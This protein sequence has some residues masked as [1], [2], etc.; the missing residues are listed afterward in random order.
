MDRSETAPALRMMPLGLRERLGEY[1]AAYEDTWRCAHGT[2]EGFVPGVYARAA[3]RR[4]RA[5]SGAVQA[6]V[7]DGRRAGILDLDRDRA[8][9]T[10]WISLLWV[11]PSL[12]GRGLGRQAVELARGMARE[13]GRACLRLSV[14]EENSAARAF[15]RALGMREAD[16]ALG[17]S[18]LLYIMELEV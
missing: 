7:L 14:A 9:D 6:L 10:L 12:R 5:W 13:L 4:E 3:Q 11:E 8:S 18:G 1:L 2:L 17:V 15:Y 16:T